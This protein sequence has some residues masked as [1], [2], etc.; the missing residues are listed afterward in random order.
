MAINAFYLESPSFQLDAEEIFLQDIMLQNSK[1]SYRASVARAACR[2]RRTKVSCYALK[3]EGRIDTL[4]CLTGE[5]Q[6]ACDRCH[7][8]GIP[9]IMRDD[10]ARKR[11]LLWVRNTQDRFNVSSARPLTKARVTLLS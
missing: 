8:S 3:D 10:D 4:K 1:K 6:S 7:F 11:F 2:A 5:G 9:C